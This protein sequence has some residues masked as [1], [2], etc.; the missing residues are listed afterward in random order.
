MAYFEVEKDTLK[1]FIVRS[2]AVDVTALGTAFTVRSYQTE[3]SIVVALD[4]GSVLVKM[5]D[6][7]PAGAKELLKPGRQISYNS[8]NRKY[9]K[10][11]VVPDDMFNWRNGVLYFEDDTFEKV[12]EELSRWYGVKFEIRNA[13]REAWHY[14]AT[15]R[16]FNLK[17]VLQSMSYTMDFDFEINPEK[18]IIK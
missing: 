10:A 1:P 2:G 16:N 17:E 11:S 14:T 7:S 5:H 3:A 18:V 12:I 8:Q 9:S 13:P 15:F 4:E 6:G